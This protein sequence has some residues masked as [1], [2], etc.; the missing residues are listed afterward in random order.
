MCYDCVWAHTRAP[1][2]SCPGRTCRSPLDLT[3]PQAVHAESFSPAVV[4]LR[5]TCGKIIRIAD[6]RMTAYHSPPKPS[7]SYERYM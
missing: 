5:V 6:V 2:W 7:Q 1:P 4:L 3:F